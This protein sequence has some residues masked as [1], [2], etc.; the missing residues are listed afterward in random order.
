MYQIL[1]SAGAALIRA[2][3]RDCLTEATPGPVSVI[4]DACGSVAMIYEHY[5]EGPDGDDFGSI[6]RGAEP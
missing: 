5:D 1:P 4:I 3:L 6:S 2:R